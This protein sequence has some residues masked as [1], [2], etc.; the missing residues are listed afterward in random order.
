MLSCQFLVTLWSPAENGLSS[1]FACVVFF[2]VFVTLSYV[3][4]ST[5]ELKFRLIMF[6]MFK[7]AGDLF[8][9]PFKGCDYFNHYFIVG[10][11]AV[12]YVPCSL[13][14]ACM[15]LLALLC[16]VFPCVLELSH[17]SLYRFLI[18]AYLSTI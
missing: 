17:T 6:N 10:F 15:D 3:S 7:H 13:V 16:V 1:W 18:F 5:S 8:W 9:R 12:I 2:C 11:Y 4:C 14:I